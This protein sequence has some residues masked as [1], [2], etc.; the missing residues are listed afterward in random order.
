MRDAQGAADL[1][2][3]DADAGEAVQGHV[4]EPRTRYQRLGEPPGGRV[5]GPGVQQDIR[6]AGRAGVREPVMGGRQRAAEV[7]P[8]GTG[9]DAGHDLGAAG[10]AAR[11]VPA[12][13]AGPAPVVLAQ[14]IRDATLADTAPAAR[15]VEQVPPVE[16]DEPGRGLPA[17]RSRFPCC[18][19]VQA[20]QS[21]ADV[22]IGNQSVLSLGRRGVFIVPGA[23]RAGRF[24]GQ[25]GEPFP[26]RGRC[27]RERGVKNLL[28]FR[29]RP[30]A[31][32]LVPGG[33]RAH[34]DSQVL[35]ERLVAHPQR[36]LQI[37]RGAAGPAGHQVHDPPPKAG[38]SA[39]GPCPAQ[40]PG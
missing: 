17:G 31:R 34:A 1:A 12:V 36:G 33:D 3:P 10:P 5:G 39:T 28:H 2:V 23:H 4:H 11:A 22:L 32:F 25:H 30:Q 9:E 40:A 27:P 6:A 8:A 29:P 26:G 20:V 16:A 35:G 13:L 15:P 21:P 14:G 19:L 37:A 38:M 18:Q 24:T 7:Q